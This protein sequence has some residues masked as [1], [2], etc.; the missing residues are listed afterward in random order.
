MEVTAVPDMSSSLEV[1]IDVRILADWQSDP[2]APS[3]ESALAE[4]GASLV[5]LALD[6]QAGTAERLLRVREHLLPRFRAVGMSPHS[7]TTDLF[8]RCNPATQSGDLRG[9]ALRLMRTLCRVA[10]DYE[11]ATIVVFPGMQESRVPYDA[12]YAAAI[13][14]LQ[15]SA[16]YALEY[17]VTIAVENVPSNFLQSPREFLG[18]LRDVGSPVVRACVNLTNVIAAGQDYPENWILALGNDL[19]LVHA[20]V[21][22]TTYPVWSTAS[23]SI[24]WGACLAALHEVQYRGALI[25]GVPPTP[26]ARHSLPLPVATVKSAVQRF[27]HLCSAPA[28][29]TKG[30]GDR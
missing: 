19:A 27:R 9:Q 7:L 21:N 10:A 12:T 28:S 1:G 5:E 14:T 2:E 15:I 18:L 29:F 30:I 23:G 11:I 16:R 22:E 17:G 4:I 8:R 13:Q 6:D 25:L 20:A 26:M 24:D 3:T